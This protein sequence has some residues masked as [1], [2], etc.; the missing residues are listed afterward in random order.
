MLHTDPA[1]T[2][3]YHSRRAQ[4]NTTTVASSGKKVD[5]RKQGLESIDNKVIQLNLK[6]QSET[7][8]KKDW[9]DASGRSGMSRAA[10]RLSL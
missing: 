7:M 8:M 3:L 10:A 4:I 5:I 1:R 9:K 2:N 6:G